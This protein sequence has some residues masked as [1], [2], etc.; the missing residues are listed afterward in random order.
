MKRVGE[1]ISEE[2]IKFNYLPLIDQLGQG[3]LFSQ[4]ISACFLYA[5]VFNR[6]D[7]ESRTFA[8]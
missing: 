8:M 5:Y 3:D 1:S 4:R 7:A 2:T 6:L